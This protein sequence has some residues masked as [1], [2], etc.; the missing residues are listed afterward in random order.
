M[1]PRT[2]PLRCTLLALTGLIAVTV[3]LSSCGSQRQWVKPGLT[4]ADF[5]QDA[6]R[7]RKEA[8][9]AHFQ[10]PFAFDAGQTMGLER[11][12]TQER[13]FEQCMTAKGYRLEERT[14][15]K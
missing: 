15:G 5:D 2:K 14:S 8:D 9:K 3:G 1:H 13:F 10:D 4:Q 12:V 11:P 6:A 7:C